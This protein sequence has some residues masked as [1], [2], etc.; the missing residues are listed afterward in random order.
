MNEKLKSYLSLGV[1]VL[2]SVSLVSFLLWQQDV[3]QIKA[4]LAGFQYSYLILAL[5]FMFLGTAISALR[6]QTIL[7]TS[8]YHVPFLFLYGLYIKGYLYNNFLP[9]QMGGDVYK[10]LILGRKIDDKS[11]ALFSVFIDRFSG[12]LVLL[13]LTIVGF[14]IDIRRENSLLVKVVELLN[15]PIS[16]EVFLYTILICTIGG[17]VLYLPILRLV[18]K[19]IGHKISFVS[20]FLKASDLI[21][22]DKEK[23]SLIL[24]Y[25]LVVQAISFTA[26]YIIFLGL[27]I[28]LR[29]MDTLIYMPITSLSALV[30]SLNGFGTQDATFSFLFSNAGVTEEIAFTASIIMHMARLIL[31]LLGGGLVLFG[32]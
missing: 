17:L 21:F 6:W 18:D 11:T 31:S 14:F 28:K 13:F 20:K 4:A 15:L 1:K 32:I 29:L 16:T 10:A 24:A 7:K 22:K 2:I 3:D 12:L 25:S 19:W 8:N 5:C 30:P 9:T 23:G 27:D 26:T